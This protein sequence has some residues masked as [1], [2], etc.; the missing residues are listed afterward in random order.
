MT[1]IVTLTL[2]LSVGL[3]AQTPSPAPNPSASTMSDE[4]KTIYALGLAMQRSIQ[5]FDLSPAELQVLLRA[6]ADS[7]ANTPAIDIKEWGPKIQALEGARRAQ[8]AVRAKAASA[9]YLVKAAGEPGVTKTPSGLIY[10][11]TVTGI[12][13]SPTGRD[14]VRVHYRGTLVDGTVF[15]SSEGREP[16]VF[17]LAQVIPCW[18]EGVPLMKVGGKAR[19]VCPSEIA[20]GDR[21]NPGIPAGSALIFDLELLEIVR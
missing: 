16:A 11:E 19:L 8:V 20:Y 21:G 18:T 7:A 4:Q 10:R 15:D 9:E 1:R 5:Q 3:L 13:V 2:L 17:S 6:F 12:G 14:R